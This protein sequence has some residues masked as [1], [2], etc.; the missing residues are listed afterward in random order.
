M[1]VVKS[2]DELSPR[3]LYNIM[4]LRLKVFVEEQNIVYVDT[5]YD[6]LQA[7]HVVN[8][9]IVSYA[10]VLKKDQRYQDHM[11][12]GRVAT[13]ITHRNKG[14]ATEILK[15]ILFT[16]KENFMIS[17]QAYLIHYYEKFGFKVVSE[18]YIEEGILHVKMRYETK[19]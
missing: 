2:F 19:I 15:T 12:I 8:D 5:D 14:Y 1:I 9:D 7:D 3:M 4:H 16:Y 17:A 10:R 11:S 13:H 6:D 18:P